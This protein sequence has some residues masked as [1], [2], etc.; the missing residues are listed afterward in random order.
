MIRFY[1]SPDGLYKNHKDFITAEASE[2]F[3][4]D[5]ANNKLRLF[6]STDFYFQTL[7]D[8]VDVNHQ[9]ASVGLSQKGAYLM[10]SQIDASINAL[11]TH[12]GVLDSSVNIIN[13]S[14]VKINSNISD[15][16]TRLATANTSIGKLT[17]DLREHK[18]NCDASLTEFSET[19]AAAL[20]DIR[21]DVDT[22]ISALEAHDS[23]L[24]NS[25]NIINRNIVNI[26]SSIRDVSTRL[27]SANTSIGGINS[28]I[29]IIDNSIGIINSSVVNINSS[30]ASINSSI[31]DV[32][33]RLSTA[34]KNIGTIN[35]SIGIINSSIGKI[36]NDLA[37]DKLEC[38]NTHE[39]FSQTWAA[40]L[41]D[42]RKDINDLK[43]Q[44]SQLQ[45]NNETN[46]T[47]ETVDT[48]E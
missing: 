7:S 43:T 39:E 11:K 32:S 44:V 37:Q 13:S 16:S 6:D 31:G 48:V 9:N 27:A 10:K 36:A 2:S 33:T 38:N 34:N 18:L 40:A 4:V 12:D 15:V 26:D 17:S 23:A 1:Y 30:I 47:N 25:V 35:S 21:M 20:I 41:V 14:I 28:S 29:G 5:K 46:N 42:I 24:D 19:W 22:S 3:V 45:T 8:T